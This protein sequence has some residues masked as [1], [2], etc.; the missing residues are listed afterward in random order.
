[1][2]PEILEEVAASGLQMQAAL[3]AEVAE[4]L[5]R[6]RYHGPSPARTPGEPADAWAVFLADPKDRARPP[7]AGRDGAHT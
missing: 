5:G 3:E 7:G 4:F 6:D 2:L 1:M